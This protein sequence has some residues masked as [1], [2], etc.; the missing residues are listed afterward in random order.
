MVNNNCCY[1]HIFFKS[2]IFKKSQYA[3]SSL[4]YLDSIAIIKRKARSFLVFLVLLIG[5]KASSSDSTAIILK[6]NV[7]FVSFGTKENFGSLNYEHIFF[8]HK[9]INWSF[10][11]GIQPFELSKKFSVPVSVN[12]FTTGRLHHLE[13]DVAATFYMNKYHPYNGGLKDD[14]NKQLYFTP[15]VCYRLQG[16]K[17]IVFKTGVGPQLLF[18]PPSDDVTDF[19]TK[20]QVSYFGALGISF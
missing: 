19:K 9:K 7:A 1:S 4:V 16:G 15:F 5:L 6:R 8:T 20:L 3:T 17:G 18:D 11:V 10:S 13:L 14:F 12:A 2:A